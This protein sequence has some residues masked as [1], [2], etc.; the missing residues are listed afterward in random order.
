MYLIDTNIFLEILLGQEKKS[1]CKEFLEQ[2]I[3]N[4]SLSDFSLHSIGVI[5]FRYGKEDLFE[6]FLDD[7]LPS[8]EILS[9][10]G[11][12]YQNVIHHKKSLNLDFDD[13]YQYSIAENSE[14]SIVTLDNDFKKVKETK[15]IFL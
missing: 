15:V 12:F 4:L 3:G 6:H 10:P 7:I 11:D 14:L 13:A 9:L 8:I 1:R 2:H 5:L